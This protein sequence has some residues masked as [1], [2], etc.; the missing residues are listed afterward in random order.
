M[1]EKDKQLEESKYFPDKKGLNKLINDFV[2]GDTIQQ[3]VDKMMGDDFEHYSSLGGSNAA[4]VLEQ[5]S[6]KI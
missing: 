3:T 4:T 6:S 1:K 5:I 2:N